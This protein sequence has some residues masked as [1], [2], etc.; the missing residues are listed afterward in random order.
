[1]TPA[2]VQRAVA[3]KAYGA[4]KQDLAR[5]AVEDLRAAW[6]ALTFWEKVVAFKLL[7]IPQALALFARLEKQDQIFLLSIRQR[8][9]LGPAVD[10]MSEKEAAAL[11]HQ[12]SDDEEDMMVK[13]I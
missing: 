12:I 6:P 10:G 11:F 5:A 3:E 8:G 13:Q 7:D 4:L 9:A 2:L 1:M